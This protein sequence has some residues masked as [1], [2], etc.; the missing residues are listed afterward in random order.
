M[1]PVFKA[2]ESGLSEMDAAPW[3]VEAMASV[4]EKGKDRAEAIAPV[5][6]GR[7]KAHFHVESGVVNGKAWACWYND[8]R[9][10]DGYLYPIALEFGT[11]HMQKQRIFGKSIDALRI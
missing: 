8:A 7:Y 11:R 10:D 9:S 1:A 3:M 6:T 2:N 5:R 4:A